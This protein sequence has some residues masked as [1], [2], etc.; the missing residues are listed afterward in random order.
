MCGYIRLQDVLFENTVFFIVAGTLSTVI[1]YVV[2]FLFF[3]GFD[4]GGDSLFSKIGRKYSL[5]ISASTINA[6]EIP[7]P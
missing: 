2:L 7:I 3:L 5:Y 4:L 1:V 6:A